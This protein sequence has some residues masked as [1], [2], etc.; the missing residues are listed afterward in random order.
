[1]ITRKKVQQCKKILV[2]GG[3]NNNPMWKTPK[4]P[5]VVYGGVEDKAPSTMPILMP[6]TP[7]TMPIPMPNT[8]PSTAS[9]A[10]LTAKTPPTPT[11]PS[12]DGPIE[13]SFEEVGIG[14]IKRP[15]KSGIDSTLTEKKKKTGKW[16]LD[17]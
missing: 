1:M 17:F 11:V 5:I 4:K 14:F 10:M 7:S 8:P 12:S 15:L 13:Y 16:L 3:E 6:N 9:V 2:S